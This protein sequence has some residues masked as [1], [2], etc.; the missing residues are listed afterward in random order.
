M[1]GRLVVVDPA[2]IYCAFRAQV[3]R[4]CTGRTLGPPRTRWPHNATKG[5]HKDGTRRG[6]RLHAKLPIPGEDASSIPPG[7]AALAPVAGIVRAAVGAHRAAA[8]AFRPA[9]GESLMQR[10]CLVGTNNTPTL[11]PL[12]HPCGCRKHD[13]TTG[14]RAMCHKSPARPEHCVAAHLDSSVPCPEQS[15]PCTARWTTKGQSWAS[16]CACTEA[17]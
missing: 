14:I 9:H 13:T 7:P 5:K 15:G 4:T 10:H 6:K 1:R 17:H 11:H 12:A 2:S 3:E 16:Y 8:E